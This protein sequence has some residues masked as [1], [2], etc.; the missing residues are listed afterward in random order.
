MTPLPRPEASA[1]GRKRH[2]TGKL[3]EASFGSLHQLYRIQRKAWIEKQHTAT[4]TTPRG[5]VNIRSAN[6]PDYLGAVHLGDRII[7]VC[8]DVKSVAPGGRSFLYPTKERHQLRSM[9]SL[10]DSGLGLGFLLL[11]DQALQVGYLVARGHD[12]LALLSGQRLELRS[13]LAH[14]NS[15]V[16]SHRPVR[17]VAGWGWDWRKALIEMERDTSSVRP[18]ASSFIV[19]CAGGTK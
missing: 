8:F 5:L 17:Y 18:N 16:T 13:A 14:D 9:L 2:R 11:I 3:L 10:T 4:V 12:L 1:A 6:P 19:H 7:T 15:F